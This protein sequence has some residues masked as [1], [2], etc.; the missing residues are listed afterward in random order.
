VGI[1]TLS[2]H[3]LIITIQS[4]V[5]GKYIGREA[6]IE[7][8]VFDDYNNPK[9]YIMKITESLIDNVLENIPKERAK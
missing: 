3:G 6:R 1:N 8:I 5:K 2:T 9:D 4:T 7:E